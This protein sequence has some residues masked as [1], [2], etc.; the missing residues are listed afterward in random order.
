M[1]KYV[2]ILSVL[3]NY[4]F[5]TYLFIFYYINDKTTVFVDGYIKSYTHVQNY[6]Y[7]Y[8]LSF[9]FLFSILIIKIKNKKLNTVMSIIINVLLLFKIYLTNRKM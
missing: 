6:I 1:P 8:V 7:A 2:Y 5:I 3:L 9:F 4:F